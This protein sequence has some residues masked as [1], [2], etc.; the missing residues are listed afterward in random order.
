LVLLS[1][2][3]VAVL[4]AILAQVFSDRATKLLIYNP[5]DS[6]IEAVVTGAFSNTQIARASLPDD[7][8]TAFGVDGAHKSTEYAAGLVVPSDFEANLRGGGHPQVLLYVNGE[9]VGV[10]QRQL[11]MQAL[12][13]Y[14]RTIA[15]PTPPAEISVST[16]NPPK[17]STMLDLSK[18]YATAA[19]LASFMVGTSLMPGLVVEEKE[20]KTL[21]MLI[22]SAASWGDI[23][24]GK[25]L[26][27]L[28]YQLLLAAVVL[29]VT[30]GFVG[31]IPLVLIF[32]LLGSLFG[33]APGLLLG[34]ILKTT[35]AASA[36]GMVAPFYILPTFAVGP[37]GQLLGNTAFGQVMKILPTYYL[38]EGVS[39]A[40]QGS[41]TGMQ[42]TVDILVMLGVTVA[43]FLAA[44][45]T[46]RRQSSVVGTL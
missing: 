20:K 33:L 10:Q 8:A 25:L 23:V 44:V 4:F 45:W 16:I 11:L 3:I 35:S 27:G 15:S 43:L 19:L 42:T 41:A 9:T 12:A 34:S 13:E 31:Q 38:A 14:S 40:M 17:P 24:A 5:S 26:V 6:A 18:F 39:N 28:G 32:G 36:T 37:F 1:P 46:L 30:K 22:V 21:R 2:I 29:A 7:V